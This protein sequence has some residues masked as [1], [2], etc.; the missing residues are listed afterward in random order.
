M[1]IT[2]TAA[3]GIS[4][5]LAGCG[6]AAAPQAPA[7]SGPPSTSPSPVPSTPSAGP[8]ATTVCSSPPA[9]GPQANFNGAQLTGV[10]F[11]SPSQGWV[12]GQHQI[13]ATAD[14]GASWTVQD[15]GALN[16]TSVDF[17]SATTGWAA[18]TGTL[19]T[20]SDG[21]SSWTALPE[22][23]Q[24]IRSVHF[25]SAQAGFAIAGGSNMLG[26][27]SGLAVA[28]APETGGVLLATTD[29]GQT[30][31]QLQAPTANAQSVCF[32]TPQDGWLGANGG[33]Y[34]STDGG[35]TWNLVASGPQPVPGS[36]PYAMI[37]QC[38]G[39]SSVWAL[40]IGAG[41]ASNQQ[42]HVGYYAGPAGA[43]ALFAEQYFP[44]PGVTVKAEAPGSYAGVMSA[45]SPQTAAYVDWC[46]PC[47]AEGTV[48][49]A[50]A[51][52]SGQLGREGDVGDL[53]YASGASF[54]SPQLGWV[55]GEVISPHGYTQRIVRTDDGGHSWQ[56]Q[57]SSG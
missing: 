34:R 10:Q 7:G 2:L 6:S 4:L 11:I 33:L 23:C 51:T 30:W 18:G 54:L 24:P 25:A 53:N 40:D 1:R 20:T 55:I 39:T 13:L 50:L 27:G 3:A 15:Q 12:V 56:V 17:I 52:D 38:A 19:L 47:G 14:G 44:H 5:L 57:Y 36:P 26:S 43:I 46:G 21:G 48:P 8:S 37:V 41:A 32:S 22:P 31:S 16:L 29:G 49:W 45:I 28:P 42:P 35:S 9:A